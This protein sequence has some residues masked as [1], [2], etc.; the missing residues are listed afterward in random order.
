[1][2]LKVRLSLAI[3][4][5]QRRQNRQHRPLELGIIVHDNRH[6]ADVRRHATGAADHLF[7]RDPVLATIVQS[8]IIDLIVVTLYQNKQILNVID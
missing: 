2:C 6:H 3:Q 5:R 4:Q 7:W 8:T 1:M